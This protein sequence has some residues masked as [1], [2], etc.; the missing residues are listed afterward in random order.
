[1][2]E[3]GIDDE[4]G[5]IALT[6]TGLRIDTALY[7]LPLLAPTGATYFHTDWTHNDQE[8]NTYAKARE[9]L[10][11]GCNFA[12][13]GTRRRRDLHTQ[14]LVIQGLVNR[15]WAQAMSTWR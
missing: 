1:M 14:S 2:A 8:Q 15:C 3:D 9:L 13:Y 7:E 5:V 10:E 4:S 11:H 12:K 6:V